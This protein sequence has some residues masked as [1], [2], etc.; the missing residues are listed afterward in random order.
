MEK[1]HQQQ[2]PPMSSLSAGGSTY[3]R[4]LLLCGCGSKPGHVIDD[5]RKI[6]WSIEFYLRETGSICL[7][8]ALDS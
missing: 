5:G 3:R 8:N 4:C 7:H 6:C 2:L 1:G